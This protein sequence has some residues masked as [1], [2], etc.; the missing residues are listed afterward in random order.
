MSGMKEPG[1]L[2]TLHTTH[3]IQTNTI[4]SP[5][6]GR[7]PPPPSKSRFCSHTCACA[8]G[9]NRHEPRS[10]PFCRTRF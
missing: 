7:N 5:L 6:A 10:I 4:H 3:L 2:Y 8:G 9:H 1:F